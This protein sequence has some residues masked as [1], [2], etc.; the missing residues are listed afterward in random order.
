MNY[1]VNIIQW[2]TGIKNEENKNKE[3]EKEN[4]K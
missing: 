3:N 4:K 1:I 2:F